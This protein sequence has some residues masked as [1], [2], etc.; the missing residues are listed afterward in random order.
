M[1]HTFLGEPPA[2]MI[3]D[4]QLMVRTAPVD[5]GEHAPFGLIRHRVLL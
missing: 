4:T 1:I 2:S 3:D 5:A